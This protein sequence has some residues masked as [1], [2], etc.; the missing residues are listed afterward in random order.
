MHAD[1]LL[2]LLSDQLRS[3]DVACR[4]NSKHFIL[5]LTDIQKKEAERVLERLKNS[6]WAKFKLP[7]E[8]FLEKKGYKL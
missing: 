2:N 3:G 5:L 7:E 6:F 4:W 8:L 1:K